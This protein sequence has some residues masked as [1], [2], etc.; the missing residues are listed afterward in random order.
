M[1][2]MAEAAARLAI[3]VIVAVAATERAMAQ[4]AAPAP[5]PEKQVARRVVINIPALVLELFE[6]DRLVAGYPIA[7]G[8]RSTPSPRGSFQVSAK[9]KNPTW[10]GP[11]NE[12]VPPGKNNPVGTRWIG[13]DKKGYGIH[14]TNA[15][16]SIGRA[17]SHGCIRMRNRD[18]ED[19]FSRVRIGDEVRIVYETVAADGTALKDIYGLAGDAAGGGR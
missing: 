1:N 13:L 9:V 3:T 12:I 14:G 10:Y 19:L 15:P 18:A 16:N 11:S 17:A 2:R 6:D 7:V 5:E 4:N 8:K